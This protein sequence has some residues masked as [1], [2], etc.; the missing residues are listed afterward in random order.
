MKN[1]S[2]RAYIKIKHAKYRRKNRRPEVELEELDKIA[3][4]LKNSRLC[5]KDVQMRAVNVIAIDNIQNTFKSF[6]TGT[7]G[8]S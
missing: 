2:E 4:H 8:P 6:A 1:R 3:I 7:F 5:D